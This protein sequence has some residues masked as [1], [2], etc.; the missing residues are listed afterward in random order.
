MS[1]RRGLG[2]GR[3]GC[4]GALGLLVG[5]I[6][7]MPVQAATKTAVTIQGGP[8]SVSDRTPVTLSADI[9]V[10]D[11]TPAPAVILAHGFGGS[12]ESVVDQATD[13]VNAGFVVAAYTARGF[14]DSTGTI[15]MNSP[16]FEIAD[17]TRVIDYLASLA[18][19]EIEG[20]NDPVVGVAGGSYGGALS[21]ML[22]GYD[23]RVDA[24]AA[25]IT[26]NDLE[27]SLFGQSMI[28]AKDPGVYKQLWTSVFF[29]SGLDSPPGQADLCGRF[30]P[31]WCAAYTEVAT[32]GAPTQASRALMRRSSPI[33]ITDRITV[34]TLLG[35]GQADSLFPLQQV[36]ANAQQIRAANPDT[37]VKVVWHAQGHDGGA[38]E[39][40]RL[41]ALTRSW[42][43][44]YLADGPAV[45]ADFE[46]SLVASSA[47]DDRE[48]DTVE[49]L[50][51]PRYPGLAGDTQRA[52]ALAGPPQRILAPAGGVPAAVSSLPGIGSL[53]G[54][55]SLLDTRV[56]P[57]QSAQFIS[58][59][60]AAP[61]QII[62]ASRVSLEVASDVARTATLF[63]GLRI[64]TGAGAL[65]LPNG[66]VAPVNVSVGPTPQ[67]VDVELPAIVAD[68]AAG[69]RLVIT[70]NTTDQAFRMPG[71]PAVYTVALADPALV[72]PEVE[73]T[74]SASGLPL[75]AWPLIALGVL[76]LVVL[77]LRLLRPRVT[78]ARTRPDLAESPLVI[79]GLVKQFGKGVRAVAGVDFTVPRG[80]VLGL[81]GPNG[82]G[83]TTTMR[84]AMG[85]IQ[86]TEGSV[87]VFGERV[88]P[89]APVLSRIGAFVEGPGFLPHLSGRENLDLYWR[90]SGRSGEPYLEQV[91]EIAGLGPSI[92]RK[93]RTYSQGMKQRLGIA[94]AMLGMPDILLLDEP[95]NGLDPPQIREMRQ[96]L[97]DYAT[98]GRTVILSSH[99]LGE[100]EQTCTHVVVMHR[101]TVAATGTVAELLAGRRGQ[102]LEDV[103]MDLVGSDH[104][105]NAGPLPEGD[106]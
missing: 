96:V 74:G 57:N 59:P 82:A 27:S 80:V 105:V 13:L 92:D 33:S 8:T 41:T 69:D 6:P 71:D 23:E 56:A 5:L 58:E 75:W 53:G 65:L 104:L 3:V 102:Q 42:F 55:L 81:L 76:L 9:Y 70:V 83:K 2:F 14:G 51:S 106:R 62:G 101:G 77:T 28:G 100:V 86:P 93:V 67:R 99:L 44:A 26:W 64:Q 4:A 48:S 89:G 32:T 18:S 90:A 63:V 24:V 7:A 95:T 97:H 84:M 91:L 37:P 45:P 10:P 52:I 60:L 47:L 22:A 25:D 17:A 11:I 85:L 73:M 38:D 50:T 1:V 30:S 39:S 88:T 87:F 98:D 66:L 12:K 19:V 15:S 21:L 20:P 29:S 94:Q 31:E 79:E 34:P 103:F 54:L 16:E 72:V 46:A 36:N 49:V 35:G 40:E 43:Q 61:L 78:G 68:V